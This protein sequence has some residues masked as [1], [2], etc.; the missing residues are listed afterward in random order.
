MSWGYLERNESRS[1]SESVRSTGQ[2]AASRQPDDAN[3]LVEATALRDDAD[4]LAEV[5]VGSAQPSGER[6]RGW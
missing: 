2:C 3:Q 5:A 1:Q 6:G 4:E